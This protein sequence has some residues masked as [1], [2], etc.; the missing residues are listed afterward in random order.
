M[1]R[2][3]FKKCHLS[4]L[5]ALPPLFHSFQ[6]DPNHYTNCY[7]TILLSLLLAVK[8]HVNSLVLE[9]GHRSNPYQ[10]PHRQSS[11]LTTTTMP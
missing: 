7:L 2:T 4:Y 3:T 1:L 11:L 10:Q 6:L 5:L 9:G 8:S